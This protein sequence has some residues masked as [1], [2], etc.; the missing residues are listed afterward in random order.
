[1]LL[2]VRILRCLCS[3]E[4]EKGKTGQ[5]PFL[6]LPLVYQVLQLRGAGAWQSSNSAHFPVLTV[7]LEHLQGSLTEKM[8]WARGAFCLT[9]SSF[10]HQSS[11]KNRDNWYKPRQT[12]LYQTQLHLSFLE[13]YELNFNPCLYEK[14]YETGVYVGIKIALNFLYTLI[15]L[16]CEHFK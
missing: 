8:H 7:F 12:L 9:C 11:I 4:T 16:S 14:T 13:K 15:L 6:T 10:S 3:K 5:E 1:M 2:A